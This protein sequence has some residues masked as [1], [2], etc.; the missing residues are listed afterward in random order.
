MCYYKTAFLKHSDSDRH[1]CGTDCGGIAML[2]LFTP[3][4]TAEFSLLPL[5]LLFV[6][7]VFAALSVSV[8]FSAQRP[9][10]G[11]IE[12][13]ARLDKAQL[14]APTVARLR[15]SDA[16]WLV[17]AAVAAAGLRCLQLLDVSGL[18]VHGTV[19]SPSAQ[20]LAQEL[21]PNAFLALGTY[22]LLR[23]LFGRPLPAFCGALSAALMQT[24]D[25]P[26]AA[27]LSFAL[28]FLYCWMCAP[29]DRAVFPRGLWLAASAV[30]LCG[31]M[32]RCWAV[33][34]LVPVWI[35][36]YVFAQVVHWRHGDP[37]RRGGR[38]ALS[39]FLTVLLSAACTLAFWAA[40][41]NL[42]GSMT[43]GADV[44]R[45]FRFYRA[46]LPLL[47]QKISELLMLSDAFWKQ[48]SIY[49]SFL[50]LC[51]LAAIVCAVHGALRLRESRC[52]L[53]L[54]LFAA[55]LVLWALGGVYL[56]P[57]PLILLLGWAWKICAER[58]HTYFVVFFLAV[59]IS[60]YGVSI[61][62]G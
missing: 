58:G 19:Q 2:G 36:A 8:Y 9:R 60:L 11:T 41:V 38:L 62:I 37:E 46:L 20:T 25:R 42:S 7:V 44:L 45:S 39:L 27:M 10:R 12:W 4:I 23:C 14:S 3:L 50:L 17:C 6:F 48:L 21:L 18:F 1:V 52:V 59:V 35:A 24:L 32:L 49:D 54:V 51:G 31:T 29:A 26:T 61:F 30:A 57:L 55:F 22:L 53:L 56:L 5:V 15:W 13:I 43:G 16:A 40:Y 28:L 47:T 34:W 33:A